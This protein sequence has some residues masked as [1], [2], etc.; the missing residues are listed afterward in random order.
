MLPTVLALF[1]LLAAP[2]FASFPYANTTAG[3]GILHGCYDG[4]TCSISIPGLPPIFGNK[5]G[6]RLVGID[7]PEMKGKCDEERALAQQAKAFLNSRLETAQEIKVEFVARDKHF[8]VLVLIIAD[9][10]D[11][12]DAM[13]EAGLARNYHGEAKSSWCTP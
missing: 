2:A 12:A 5:L 10:L 1:L 7:T 9:G 4:D 8:R 13:V 11:L 6:L 3:I